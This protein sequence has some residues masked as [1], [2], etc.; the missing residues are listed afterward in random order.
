MHKDELIQLHTLLCQVRSVVERTS[1]APVVNF[2]DYESYGVAPQHI[3]KSKLQH[4]RAVFLLGK[5]LAD[6][7]GGT[8]ELSN[9]HKISVRLAELAKKG[10]KAPMAPPTPG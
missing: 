5:E 2:K 6:A 7:L 9:T 10:T 8:D 1:E 4:K 3:H